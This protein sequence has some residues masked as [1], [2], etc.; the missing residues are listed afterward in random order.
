MDHNLLIPARNGWDPELR[1]GHRHDFRVNI[2]H[3]SDGDNFSRTA[4]CPKRVQLGVPRSVRLHA[5]GTHV[6]LPVRMIG[7]IH[8]RLRELDEVLGHRP[9]ARCSAPLP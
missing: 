8:D 2:L 5:Q 6:P 3:P 7:Q 1:T 4:S 9:T